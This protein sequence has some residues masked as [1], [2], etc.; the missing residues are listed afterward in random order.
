MC[1]SCDIT[2]CALAEI[3]VLSNQISSVSLPLI[4]LLPTLTDQGPSTDIFC[5]MMPFYSYDIPHSCGP[6]PKVQC[7][8]VFVCVCVCVCVG[9]CGCDCVGVGSGVTNVASPLQIC[10]QFDF[11]RLPGNKMNCPWK[12]RPEVITDKNVAAK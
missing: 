11:K 12:I 9:G 1:G 7:V 4:L 10:C 8:C 5:H 6:D 3:Y 2:I